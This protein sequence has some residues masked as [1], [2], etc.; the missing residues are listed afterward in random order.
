MVGESRDLLF[1]CLTSC[2][3]NLVFTLFPPLYLLLTSNPNCFLFSCPP[4]LTFR[5]AASLDQIKPLWTL[6]STRQPALYK[7]WPSPK[8]CP[9]VVS[10]THSLQTDQHLSK[11]LISLHAIVSFHVSQPVAYFS[12]QPRTLHVS[13]FSFICC[14][15]FCLFCLIITSPN[16]TP[17]QST[18]A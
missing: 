8:V 2:I 10:S 18:A 13:Y 14:C 15:L 16:L 7:A 9:S 12:P 11:Q 1:F 3:N 5:P 17:S 6:A 4:N